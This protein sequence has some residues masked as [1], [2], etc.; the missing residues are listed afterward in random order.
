MLPN[1]VERPVLDEP[2]PRASYGPG[3]P[4]IWLEL[5]FCCTELVSCIRI[6]SSNIF[7]VSIMTVRN[8]MVSHTFVYFLVIEK[9]SLL[10]ERIN[11]PRIQE[12]ASKY[13]V[14][15]PVFHYSELSLVYVRTVGG[16]PTDRYSLCGAE[17]PALSID[18]GLFRNSRS[19]LGSRAIECT[20]PDPIIF[21][22]CRQST[23]NIDP[24]IS[25]PTQDLE[26]LP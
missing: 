10:I 23:H 6:S 12:F 5:A 2:R 24:H 9:R 14:E 26:M 3:L 15:W 20:T 21:Y 7:G 1:P 25:F 16:A 4:C 18:V 22:P 19:R 8:K 13:Y 17:T 11:S